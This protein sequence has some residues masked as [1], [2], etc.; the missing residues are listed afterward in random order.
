[1]QSK[2]FRAGEV[3][4]G[5]AFR[6]GAPFAG[7]PQTASVADIIRFEAEQLGNA[8]IA[9]Q[10]FSLGILLDSVPYHQCVWVTPRL[11]VCRW[12]AEVLGPPFLQI[13]EL[14][15]CLG[16]AP[17]VLACDSDH[18]YLVLKR[19]ETPVKLHIVSEEK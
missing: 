8:D 14:T 3:Y 13:E 17:L 10:A 16:H 9:E 15:S 12:Y 19:D 7:V 4:V 1:M 18:G 6:A 11:E 2:V 5:R